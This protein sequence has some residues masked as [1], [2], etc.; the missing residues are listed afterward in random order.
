MTSVATFMTLF[1]LIGAATV[2]CGTINTSL[3]L[4]LV[5]IMSDSAFQGHNRDE[6]QFLKY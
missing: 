6:D 3:C 2:L 4:F 1:S 5:I